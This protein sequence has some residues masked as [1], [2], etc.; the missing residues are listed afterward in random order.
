M[1]DKCDVCGYEHKNDVT[2]VIQEMPD[3]IKRCKVCRHKLMYGRYIHN[4]VD[5][6][7]AELTEE[8]KKLL[9]EWE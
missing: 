6:F 2:P 3:G 1:M 8:Y 7:K 5:E 9:E 4:E